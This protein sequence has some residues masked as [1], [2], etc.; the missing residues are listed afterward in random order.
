MHGFAN[1]YPCNPGVYSTYNWVCGNPSQPDV[2]FCDTPS[3]VF[4]PG[5]PFVPQGLAATAMST[6]I[7]ATAMST[8][9]STV[10]VTS[11]VTAQPSLSAVAS[12]IPNVNICPPHNNAVLGVGLGLGIGLGLL[13]I[14]A[15]LGFFMERRKRKSAEKTFTQAQMSQYRQGDRKEGYNR[16][17]PEYEVGSQTL[18]EIQS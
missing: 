3:F 17:Q 1:F 9:T 11:S 12:A 7:A 10:I 6:M 18:H 16:S 5:S 4:Q 15:L 2:N 13:A 14:A 8:M